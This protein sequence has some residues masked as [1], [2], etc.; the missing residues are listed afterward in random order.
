[1]SNRR[2][3]RRLRA[4]SEFTCSL[5]GGH[6][7]YSCQGRRTFEHYVLNAMRVRPLRCCDCDGLCYAFPMRLDDPILRGI[8]R[9]APIFKPQRAET[10][11]RAVYGGAAAHI[12]RNRL[13]RTTQML[14]SASH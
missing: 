6:E 4:S 9:I 13:G 5:C 12:L 8:E 3:A 2:I 7:A 14:P 1:M 11:E 10:P